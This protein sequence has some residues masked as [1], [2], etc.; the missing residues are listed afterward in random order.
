MDAN[1]AGYAVVPFTQFEQ[2]GIDWLELGRRRH[3]MHGLM[4][5]D[6]TDARRAIHKMRVEAGEPISF[7]AFIVASLARAVAEDKRMHAY[8]LGRHKLV[9]FDD[10]DVAL[11][12]EREMEGS[13]APVGFVVRAADKKPLSAIHQEIRGAQTEPDPWSGLTRW[14]PLWLRLP[15]PIRRVVWSAFLGDPRRRKRLSGTV[16][17]S[18]V[19]MFGSGPGWGIPVGIPHSL[20]LTVGSIARKPWV[21]RNHEGDGSKSIEVREIL[22]LTVSV[23]HDVIQGAAA[24]RFARRLREL[25]E[26]GTVLKEMNQSVTP[27][28]GI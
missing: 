20:C 10:V 16:V 8:R 14:F 12:V 1:Q 2:S 27:A 18:A 9:L 13:K 6:V 17:V 28:S 24:A 7:T 19:G 22:S 4:E 26:S 21:V 25:I 15:A 11:A 23:D 3:T 5:L